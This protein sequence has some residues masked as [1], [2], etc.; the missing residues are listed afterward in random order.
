VKALAIKVIE[1]TDCPKYTGSTQELKVFS[2]Q[3]GAT[4]CNMRDTM[5]NIIDEY[6]GKDYRQTGE[7]IVQSATPKIVDFIAYYKGC[8][9]AKA[10]I[11]KKFTAKD[12]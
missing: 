5:K 10:E 7:P 8:V 3:T 12:R 4:M 9:A 6:I 11:T 2:S 1:A